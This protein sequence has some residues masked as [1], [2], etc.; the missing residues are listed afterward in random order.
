M[1]SQQNWDNPSFKLVDDT[2]QKAS[3]FYFKGDNGQGLLAELSAYT[4]V[5]AMKGE[6]AERVKTTMLSPS[7][8]KKATDLIQKDQT[9]QSKV[10]SKQT[11]LDQYMIHYYQN[12]RDNGIEEADAT[13]EDYALQLDRAKSDYRQNRILLDAELAN[14]NQ[15][16]SER[17]RNYENAKLEIPSNQNSI[18]GMNKVIQDISIAYP[19]YSPQASQ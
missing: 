12:I 13:K 2:M 1:Y 7:K 15:G 9:L 10:Q 19:E 18:V 8:A 5:N 17:L 11:Q 6:Q 4:M 16:F 14:V 3:N